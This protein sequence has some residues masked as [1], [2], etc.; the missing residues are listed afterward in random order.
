MVVTLLVDAGFGERGVFRRLTGSDWKSIMIVRSLWY[1]GHSG[2]PSLTAMKASS[3]DPS[4]HG[5]PAPS[6]LTEKEQQ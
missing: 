6:A 2:T 5:G 1:T 4:R 3:R